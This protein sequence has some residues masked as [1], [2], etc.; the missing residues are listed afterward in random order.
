MLCF[1]TAVKLCVSKYLTLFFNSTQ[2]YPDSPIHFSSISIERVE[3]LK[4]AKKK[5]K[6]KSKLKDS[7]CDRVL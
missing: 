3:E 1:R 7:K 2:P 6:E 5:L 4:K